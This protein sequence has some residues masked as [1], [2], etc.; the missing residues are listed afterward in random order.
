M[1][2]IQATTSSSAAS[3]S[4]NSTYN[5]TDSD[6]S[7]LGAL[8]LL[9]TVYTELAKNP[10]GD[11]SSLEAAANQ[12]FQNALGGLQ[13]GDPLAPLFKEVEPYLNNP[14]LFLQ[15]AGA[16]KL[17]PA[18]AAI[19]NSSGDAGAAYSSSS[20]PSNADTQMGIDSMGMLSILLGM[21]AYSE[22][23]NKPG[24]NVET[25]LTTANT[26]FFS[27]GCTFTSP[28]L[29]SGIFGPQAPTEATYS[30]SDT[31]AAMVYY[32]ANYAFPGGYG[33]EPAAS[34]FCKQFMSLAQ[35]TC[36]G[37][38]PGDA[39]FKGISS[40]LSTNGFYSDAPANGSWSNAYTAFQYS[41]WIY[42]HYLFGNTTLSNPNS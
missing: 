21:Q 24:S 23:T 2:P 30:V 33:N 5:L 29:G 10:S 18:I 32:Y 41:M 34:A 12:L 4:S 28:T 22:N 36:T 31:F 9:Y 25:F 3:G 14:A 26:S 7:G 42:L 16:M 35:G 17:V 19:L 15:Q 20:S 13:S 1:S 37:S 8:M 11:Y 6:I 40:F 39:F 27:N 38:S